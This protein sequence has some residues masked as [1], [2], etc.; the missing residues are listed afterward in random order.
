[1]KEEGSRI[2]KQLFLKVKDIICCPNCSGD[3]ELDLANNCLTCRTDS[4]HNFPIVK[5]IPSFV[6]REEISPEDAEW[7]SEYDEKAEQ[8]DEEIR[9]G[10]QRM[11]IDLREEFSRILER[12]PVKPSCH[13]LDVS[14]GTGA[15]IFGIGE[16]FPDVSCEFVGV[17]LSIGM[18]RVAQGKFTKAKME[19]PL[20]H[21]EVMKL[22][23]RDGSFD[24][25]THFGGINTF[26]DIPSALK[27]WVRVLKM[28]GHLLVVDEGVSP[29]LRK[30]RKGANLIKENWLFGLQ[31]PL[32]YLPPQ[33]KRVELRWVLKDM[34]YAISCQ[35]L[36]EDELR[37][38]Q[39][40]RIWL[41]ASK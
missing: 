11:G 29:A 17:D 6:K 1:M 2:F 25:I 32:E 14:T 3:L 26:R 27:D 12:V 37:E 40:L 13:I 31:P 9:R 34:F 15:L 22:P 8:Y 5:G 20:F 30:T 7:V 41:A 18:L 4:L 23:F 33:V 36:S 16:V 28:K 19:V 10:A 38:L 35:K 21:S 39:P 24:I